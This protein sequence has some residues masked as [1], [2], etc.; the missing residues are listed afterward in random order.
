MQ[1]NN[2]GNFDWGAPPG[3]ML[4]PLKRQPEIK[5]LKTPKTEEDVA[6]IEVQYAA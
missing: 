1:R 5:N 3:G 4:K 6:E 2:E